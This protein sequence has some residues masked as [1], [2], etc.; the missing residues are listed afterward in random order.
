MFNLTGVFMGIARWYMPLLFTARIIGQRNHPALYRIRTTAL[1]FAVKHRSS[2]DTTPPPL[3]A[4][5]KS[6]KIRKVA[7]EITVYEMHYNALSYT[8]TVYE[9]CNN[10]LC[11]II[12]V[13]EK[14]HDDLSSLTT[15]YGI[16]L[17]D[18]FFFQFWKFIFYKFFHK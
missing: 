12:T 15:V 10:D 8:I 13:Y 9:I 18:W 2:A 1:G 3:A 16:C 5:K 6:G 11:Q 4:W 17:N 7:Y 14:Y